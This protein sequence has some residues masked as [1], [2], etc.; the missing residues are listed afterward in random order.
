LKGVGAYVEGVEGL[1]LVSV[2]RTTEW[3]N[4]DI[5]FWD[6]EYGEHTMFRISER[7]LYMPIS[8]APPD[9]KC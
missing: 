3:D 5:R 9:R 7:L 2:S 4:I 1:E 8:A 6:A